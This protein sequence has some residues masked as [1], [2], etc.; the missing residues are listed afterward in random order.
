MS[1]PVQ[2]S[3]PLSDGRVVL[4]SERLKQLRRQ[5]GLSQEA[6]AQRCF[7]QRLC[8][9]IA[10]IKRAETLKPVLYRTARHLASFYSVTL[11]ELLASPLAPANAPSSHSPTT[12]SAPEIAFHE[13]R[14]VVCLQL[15]GPLSTAEQQQ[16]T[17][18]V[19]QF[20]GTAAAQTANAW[21]A[22][23]GLPCAYRS[24]AQRAVRCAELIQQQLGAQVSL[25]LGLTAWPLPADGSHWWPQ[26]ATT[27]SGIRLKTGLSALLS[28]DYT[29]SAAEP[30]WEWLNGYVDSAHEALLPLCG[31]YL[32]MQQVK[33]ILDYTRQDQ[34]GHILYVR[35]VAGIGKSRLVAECQ[36]LAASQGLHSWQGAVLD[37]GDDSGLNALRELLC[38]LLAQAS[39]TT[40]LPLQILAPEAAL[41]LRMLLGETLSAEQAT[42]YSAMTQA[43]RLQHQVAGLRELLLRQAILRPLLLT[44]EDLHWATPALFELLLPLL[45]L[46]DEAPII[47]L[48]TSRFEQ[49]PLEH[50]L[51]PQLLGLPLTQLDLAPLRPAEAATMAQ[52]FS[53]VDA[54]YRQQ[55]ISQ[56]QGHPLFLSLLLRSG[57]SRVLPDSVKHLIQTKMDQFTPTDR[58]ALRVAAAAGAQIELSM[59]RELLNDEGYTPEMPIRHYLMRTTSPGY[60]VFIHDLIL[61]GIYESMISAQREHIHARIA[62]YYAPRDLALQAQHLLKARHPQAPQAFVRAIEDKLQRQLY[63]Q[64]FELTQR[65]LAIDYVSPDLCTLNLLR[66]QAASK[67]GLTQEARICFQ[68][69]KQ[70]AQQISQVLEAVVGLAQTLNLLDE[71]AAEEQLLDEYL[72]AALTA[73][74]YRRAAELSYL[75]GNL[76]FPRGDFARCRAQHQA[77]LDFARQ[78]GALAIEAKALGG[79]GDSY[80]VE[81]WMSKAAEAIR[82][83]LA[84][85]EQYGFADTEAANRFML[86]TVRLYAN[87]TVPALDDALAAAEL[88]R[89]VGNRRAEVVSRLTA[90]W[91]LLSLLRLSEAEQ[92]IE[93]GLAVARQIGAGRF[94]P[95]LLE[96]LAR[97]RYLQGQTDQA[98]HL[99]QQAWQQVERFRLQQF[100]GPWV[101]GTLALL[102]E[103]ALVRED[104]LAQGEALLAAGCVGHNAYRF[105]VAAA[106]SCILA[107]EWAAAQTHIRALAM[108]S[109]RDPCPWVDHHV[110]LLEAYVQHGEQ[111]HSPQLASLQQRGAQLGLAGVLPRLHTE[112]SAV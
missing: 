22:V 57:R 96:S 43:S 98:R 34:I 17:E 107:G 28:Q 67:L 23:F 56:A 73:Q 74:D 10:S 30:G 112:L 44:L 46:V 3:S 19:Q 86:G 75:K 9:S 47:W 95:F 110:A 80:Y 45:N 5:S 82:A 66:A 33:S 21:R 48:L 92:Q 25:Q 55:C 36:E 78:A 60:L 106:E 8:V 38:S 94:E 71:L 61:R 90:G 91:A 26:P 89:S 77:A 27:A 4:D 83:C 59:L 69:A 105:R 111:G 97:I 109:S 35:G 13:Q 63:E 103:R 2:E 20:G 88:G 51:R 39:K 11:E 50:Y 49:D 12:R 65:A 99:I 29:L 108:L 7:E 72:P 62:D 40:P 84:L 6:L 1:Q 102:D 87:E 41:C 100:I 37:F 52:Q 18:L 24:D 85:C 53:Q 14:D 32:E 58:Q 68:A 54:T 31:R 93:Q 76:Y 81:G 70:H 15:N 101:L 42:L 64:A 104:A 79:I 16:L